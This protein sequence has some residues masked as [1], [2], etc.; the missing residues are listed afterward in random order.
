MQSVVGYVN[1][2][3]LKLGPI[4]CAEKCSCVSKRSLNGPMGI[5]HYKFSLRGVF[6]G[7]NSL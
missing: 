4:V 2:P 5:Y 1:Y 6:R 3:D 7:Q